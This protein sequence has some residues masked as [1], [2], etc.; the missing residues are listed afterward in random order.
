MVNKIIFTATKT[1]I[2]LLE[3][4]KSLIEPQGNF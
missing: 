1:A 3:R 2:I 4:I